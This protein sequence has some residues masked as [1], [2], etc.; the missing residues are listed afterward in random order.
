MAIS[1]EALWASGHDESVEVNQRAL[2]DKVLARYSGEFTVF[3]ELLQNSDDA[4]AKEVEIHFE[5]KQFRERDAVASEAQGEQPPSQDLPNLKTAIVHRWCFKNN[6][7]LFRDEDWN[8]LRKIAEGNPDEEKIGAFGVGFYSLFSVTEEPFVSSGDEWMGFYWKDNKDQL[9]ARRGKLP[10]TSPSD[11]WTVFDMPL[12]ESAT[13]PPPFDLTRFL[14]SSITFM[15]NLETVSIFFDDKRLARLQKTVGIPREISLAP[16]NS[17]LHKKHKSDKGFM[18]VTSIQQTALNIKAEVMTWVYISGTEKRAPPPTL[19]PKPSVPKAGGFFSSLFGFSTPQRGNTPLP[20]AAPKVEEKKH[21]PHVIIETS[22]TLSTFSAAIEV[23]LD[24]KTSTELQR[25]TKKRPPAKMK[26]DM[27]YTGKTEY[28]LSKGEDDSLPF[29]TGSVFQGLR[30]D[31]D[32]TGHAKIFIGHSTGQTTGIGGHMSARFIPT[33]ERE[34][35]DLMDRNVAV[36]NRELLWVGGYLCRCAYELELSNIQMLWEGAIPPKASLPSEEV[37]SQLTA[38]ALHASRFFTFRTSTPSADISY[39][40][41]TAFFSCAPPDLPIMSLS[42]IRPASTVR[43]PDPQFTGFLKRLPVLPQQMLD[44]C[45]PMVALLREKRIIKETTFQDVLDELSARPLMEEE[46]IACLK[47]WT[48]LSRQGETSQSPELLRVR[49]Q[50]INAALLLTKDTTSTS[51][52]ER[53]VPLSVIESF[54]NKKASSGSHIPTT[55]PLPDYVL[56]FSISQHFTADALATAMPWN[57]FT[58][59]QWLAHICSSEGVVDVEHDISLSPVYAEEVLVILS[60]SLPSLP[61]KSQPEIRALLKS[62]TCIPTSGG[63]MTAENSYFPNADIFKDLPVVKLPSGTPIKGNL[64]KVLDMLGV[65]KHVELQMVFDKIKTGD[66]TIHDLIKYL[67]S[68]QSALSAEEIRRLELTSAF[69]A[70][71]AYATSD[72]KTKRYQARELYEPLDI[73]R[74]LNLPVIAWGTNP[75]WRASSEEAKFLFK[76]GLRK[77]PPLTTLINKCAQ[78]EEP[79]RTAAL[80]YLLDN[81]TSHYVDYHPAQFGTIPFIPSLKDGVDS[82]STPKE[83]YIT[84][85]WAKLGFSVLRPVTQ[86]PDLGSKLKLQRHPSPDILISLLQRQPP[87]DER[88]AKD[89]FEILASR[90]PEFNSKHLSVL[91]ETS[92][93]PTKSGEN[94]SLRYL[95][96]SRCFFGVSGRPRLHSKLFVFVDFGP[97][98]KGFLAACGTKNEPSVEEVAQILISD[99]HKFYDMAEGTENF[100]NELR[101]IAVNNSS[102][103]QGTLLRLKKGPVLLGIRRK[104]SGGE[105]TELEEDTWDLQYDLKRADQIIVADDTSSYQLFG[106]KFFAAPQ[107]DLLENFYVQLGSKRLSSLVKEKYLTSTEIKD[108]RKAIEIRNLILERL[109]LFL[110]EHTHGDKTRIKFEWLESEENFLVKSF[111]KVEVE[112][113][114]AYDE[115]RLNKTQEASAVAT[116]LRTGGPL[117]LWLAGHSQV[118]MYEIAV[119]L[120]RYLFSTPK[121]ND[122]LLF[123]TILS[124]DLRSLKRRGYNV[125]R[126]LRKQQAQRKA[127]EDMAKAHQEALVSRPIPKMPNQVTSVAPGPPPPIPP[128]EE[129]ISSPAA[130]DDYPTEAQPEPSRT[131][132]GVLNRLQDKIQ[133]VVNRHDPPPVST[134]RSSSRNTNSTVTPLDNI[135][136]NINMAVSACRPEQAQLIRNR[137]QMQTV[138]ESLNEGYCD[139]S[140]RGGDMTFVGMLKIICCRTS[141]Q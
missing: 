59:V 105:K 76:L 11:P 100:L 5:T 35:I 28:D 58:I 81:L 107:E 25:S 111:G 3:R 125:D 8:R 7:I 55:G 67:V 9:I 20:P 82:M 70:E 135:A 50:L 30:A 117:Q 66:W 62:K 23:K 128:K 51:S 112:K 115:H 43:I 73:M 38:M 134:D 10:E 64:E 45:A 24:S 89:W 126:I 130:L 98:A 136:S 79:I 1:R 71:G 133:S 46:M 104:P 138:K 140:G 87:K 21:D 17:H 4:R 90:I 60:R 123:M 118:D 131:R 132:T 37:Q 124:T 102:L 65:R 120:C 88:Q 91:S 78:E 12:R 27:I 110:H 103:S 57:E 101:N 56:P 32:G 52:S 77:F 31:L 108:S 129:R 119:S 22:V 16:V 99:P 47:W 53:I 33:V 114:L 116:R 29:K 137:Q 42:G 86:H 94:G 14:A 13:I 97:S 75:R 40:L 49:T 141:L 122:A 109:P 48:T 84:P 54:I 15:V 39:H 41:Q 6:G 95:P 121:P 74:N 26:C 36:W 80:K 34:S 106:D 18:N 2:I 61:H 63:M 92:F 44:D 113:S 72:G 83:V 96:P 127:A 19:I 68:V 69:L 139:I 93:V 85:E